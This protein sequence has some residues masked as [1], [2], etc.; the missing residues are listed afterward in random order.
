[1][2]HITDK[3]RLKQGGMLYKP[4]VFQGV[5]FWYDDEVIGDSVPVVALSGSNVP[6]TLG[7]KMPVLELKGLDEQTKDISIIEVDEQFNV[8]KYE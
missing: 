6:S 8:I 5:I 2:K 1:M 4:A 7:K 3:T